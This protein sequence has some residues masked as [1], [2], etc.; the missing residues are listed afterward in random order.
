MIKTVIAQDR[1]ELGRFVGE[2]AAEVLR[3]SLETRDEC[4]LVIA[5]G[6]SQFEA[7]EALVQQPGIE[8]ERVNGFHLDEYLGI[9]RTHSASF[10]G[11]LAQRFVERV[12]LK[13]FFYLDGEKE[14]SSLLAEANQNLAGKTIDLL[15]CGIGENGHLAFNDPPADFE[16]DS[17]YLLVDLDEPCRKQQVGEGWFDSLDQVP[18][19]AI[20]MSI[21][22]ILAANKI[23]CAVPDRRKA[24]AVRATLEDEISPQVPA[25]ALRNHADTM[26][27]LDTSSS[28]R[29]SDESQQAC[30]FL[31]GTSTS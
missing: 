2:Q 29:L 24:E 5:T 15:L 6:S 27:I 1:T 21:P 8:W 9:P 23:L 25:S 26:L 17:P 18:L 22:Q 3:T 11:Y 16:A 7:L 10:C 19:R 4:N 30:V 13:S 31:N 20:S 12:P 14:P 28:S